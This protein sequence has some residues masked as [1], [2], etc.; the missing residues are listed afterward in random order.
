MA[1]IAADAL[2]AAPTGKEGAAPGAYQVVVRPDRSE[3]MQSQRRCGLRPGM[4]VQA[5]VVTRS[6]RAD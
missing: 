3:L 2:Q 5:D 6:T 4:Q 1:A